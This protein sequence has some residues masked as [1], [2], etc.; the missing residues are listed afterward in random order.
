MRIL[1]TGA[2]GFIGSHLARLLS[3][4]GHEVIGVDSF[5]P[6]YDR[7]IKVRNLQ[8]AQ[9]RNAW[10][11]LEKRSSELTAGD[12]AGVDVV[13]HLAA[14]PGVRLSWSA[15]DTYLDENLTETNI[16]ASRIIE[17]GV[18]RVVF[19]SSSSVYGDGVKYP[20]SES[21]RTTPRSPY[22]VTKLAGESLWESY[23]LSSELEV[24]ALRFFTVYGPGQRPDMAIQRL[25]SA[26]LT[27]REFT[28]FGNGEQRRDF[29]YVADVARAC[30][31]ACAAPL[32][33]PV[34]RLNIGGSGDTSMND[35]IELVENAVG[36][37]LDLKREPAQRGDVLRTG[38]DPALARQVL[39]W[40][41]QVRISEGVQRQVAFE[42]SGSFEDWD[43]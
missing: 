17:A 13:V 32:A 9:N 19:A 39:Q 8:H 29:T 40:S 30:A 6:Y 20:T 15:F 23:A 7:A 38:A 26:A 10:V 22:G 11:F 42:R 27:G 37:P 35:L 2:A 33:E 18:K 1:I 4:N 43:Q 14:Q 21:S 34:T 16:L 28:L 41:P 3:A 31:A 5:T 25:V 36:S 24:A 12:L